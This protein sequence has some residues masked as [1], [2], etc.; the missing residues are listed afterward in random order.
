MLCV[1]SPRLLFLFAM[2]LA[3]FV[4][5]FYSWRNVKIAVPF[6]TLSFFFILTYCKQNS[7]GDSEDLIE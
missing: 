6:L 4:L 1:F 5:F 2:L 3:S 7:Q